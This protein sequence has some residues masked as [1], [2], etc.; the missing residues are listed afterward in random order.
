MRLLHNFLTELVTGSTI[1]TA[2]ANTARRNQRS[3]F[4]VEPSWA[5][6]E[7]QSGKLVSLL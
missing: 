2:T 1:E 3:F 5:N 6:H 7:E 4:M